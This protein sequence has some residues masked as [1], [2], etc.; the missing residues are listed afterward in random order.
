MLAMEGGNGTIRVNKPNRKMMET[1]IV[2]MERAKG[3]I[4]IFQSKDE[5]TGEKHDKEV[6]KKRKHF[7]K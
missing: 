4:A 5:P 1:R 6:K 7:K 2:I 3:L